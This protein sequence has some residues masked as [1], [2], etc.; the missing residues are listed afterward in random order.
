VKTLVLTVI[1]DDRVGL[2]EAIARV[3]D[4][5]GGNWEHSELA[6]LAGTFAG[7]IEISVPAARVEELRAALSGLDGL[8]TVAVHS[9]TPVATGERRHVTF[10]V[11][12]NDHPGIVREIS[13]ALHAHAVGID[14]LTSH[15]RDA[16]MSGGR[17]FEA[18][19]VARV[20]ASV[21]LDAVRTEL[22]RLAAEVQVDIT[23]EDLPRA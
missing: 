5:H 7:V 6:E 11:L 12:G 15:T 18:T 17:L 14:H 4:E 19:I 8:L 2:V 20:P 9:T 1:G 16:A 22:E 21:D 13:A 3:V 10:G 23:I